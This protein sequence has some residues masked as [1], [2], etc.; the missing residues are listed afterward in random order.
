ML[1]IMNKSRQ[2]YNPRETLLEQIT[3]LDTVRVHETLCK[4][5]REKLLLDEGEIYHRL[6]QVSRNAHGWGDDRAARNLLVQETIEVLLQHNINPLVIENFW[7]MFFIQD[8]RRGVGGWG[9]LMMLCQ[10]YNMTN[11]LGGGWLHSLCMGGLSQS[12]SILRTLELSSQEEVPELTETDR[13]GKTALEVLWSALS[14][15][16]SSIPQRREDDF[17]LIVD[18]TISSCL[19]KLSETK[20]RVRIV[21]YMEMVAAAHTG[22]QPYISITRAVSILKRQSLRKIVDQLVETGPGYWEDGERVL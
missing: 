21:E 9:P 18:M 20:I 1:W 10:K 4:M 17:S 5:G 16:K 13:Q 22:G 19:G 12:Q 8:W 14:Q 3:Q 11:P 6:W 7:T 15:D 2:L